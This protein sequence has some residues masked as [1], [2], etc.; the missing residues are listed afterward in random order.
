[1]SKAKVIILLTAFIDVVGIGIVIPTLPSYVQRLSDSPFL[2]ASFFAIYSFFAFFATPV[3]G[4]LSDRYGRRPVLIISLLGTAI[5]WFVFAWGRNVAMLVLGRAI[6]GITSGN[7]ATAQNYLAD[8]A[9][10]DQERA[11]NLG[12]I[13]AVFGIGFIVGPAAGALLSGISPTF[14]FWVAGALALAN[15]VAAYFFLPESL[16]ER[17]RTTSVTLNPL[18]GIGFAYGHGPIRGLLWAWT[19]FCLAV[20]AIPAV[21]ALYVEAAFAL[22]PRGIGLLFAGM[23]LL[24]AINQ[25]VLLRRFWLR[26][27]D[28]RG[29]MWS[30]A[31]LMLLSF[32]CM[33][34][35]NFWLFLAALVLNA[36]GQANLRVSSNSAIIGRSPAAQQG[37]VNGVV[38]S[39]FFLSSVLAP[40]YAG[41]LMELDVR[42]PWL[43]AAGFIA[44]ALPFAL[45][46]P[47]EPSQPSPQPQ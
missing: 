4:S 22:S 11:A 3:L 16:R 29:L 1:M 14:P 41:A 7:I 9:R 13:G 10:D 5:G 40:L 23:G 8:L 32:A 2:A 28:T 19:F 44:L 34:S 39:V 33:A 27:F 43:A 15:T 47:K 31:L 6:D 24:M 26:R 37:M 12:M 42:L 30:S 35:G 38:Q 36:F 25:G 21:F 17:G 20:S 18:R 45:R 46:L